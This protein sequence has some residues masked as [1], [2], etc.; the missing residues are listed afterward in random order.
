M[1][2]LLDTHLLLWAASDP[3]R[4]PAPAVAMIA[5]PANQPLFSAISLWEI[6]IKS[7]L[8]RP[9]FRVDAARLRRGLSDNGYEELALTAAHALFIATLPPLHKDPFD[10][11][12]IAQAAVE[13]VLLLT[14][15]AALDGYPGPIRWV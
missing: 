11:A 1:K 4:I 5:D 10:R 9:D 13:G 7:G 15:D 3:G 8:G 14:A 12:L 2:V 6:V